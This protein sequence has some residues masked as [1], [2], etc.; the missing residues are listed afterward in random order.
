[1]TTGWQ[2]M[3]SLPT[4]GLRI[5]VDKKANT[6]RWHSKAENADEGTAAFPA[7]SRSKAKP[8]AADLVASL[9]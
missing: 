8:F 4:H 7:A 6:M 9:L 1:M 2:V 5:C 3:R